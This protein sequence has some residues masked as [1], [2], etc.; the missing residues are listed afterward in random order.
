[1]DKQ[2][3]DIAEPMIDKAARW[4][5]HDWKGVMEY[6][7]L[8]Q[9]LWLFLLES[10]AM[11]EKVLALG[12][13]EE[14]QNRFR[15]AANTICSKE[16]IAYEQ[17][18]GNF[19]Y[20]PADVRSIIETSAAEREWD[21]DVDYS[22]GLD[23]LCNWFPKQYDNFME[24]MVNGMPEDHAGEMR[25]Y[26]SIDK[27]AECMNNV[28]RDRNKEARFGEGPRVTRASETPVSSW[29]EFQTGVLNV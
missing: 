29:E 11:Q 2:V 9:E 13:S 7:D 20:T 14:L 24:Y 1:M 26:R 10:P 8:H 21:E 5:H 4:A 6:D 23:R 27:L 16:Q 28:R 3:L 25:V 12:N 18:T 17:F 22:K 19:Q 15:K